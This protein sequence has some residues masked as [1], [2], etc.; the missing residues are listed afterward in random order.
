MRFSVYQ[1]SRRGGREKN[2]DRLGYCYTRDAGLFAL[3][4]GM[5]GHPDGEVASQLA[6]QTLAAHFQRISK[7]KLEDPVRF[8]REGIVKGHQQLLRYTQQKSLPDSPRTT[9]VACL[10]QDH[11]AYWA[12]CGDSRFYLIR[13]GRVLHRT[14]D[15]SYAELQE[16]LHPQAAQN[17][18][19][20]RNVLFTCLG[21]P[22][23]PVIDSVG[24]VELMHGDK[25][26]L[27]SDGLWGNMSDEEIVEQLS[28]Q[29]LPAAVPELVDRALRQGG[30]RCD[31]VSV[32]AIEWEDE[33]D[34][35]PTTGISTQS[36]A[37]QAFSSTIQASLASTPEPSMN[38]EEMDRSTQ[39]INDNIRR[40]KED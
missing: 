18:K 21:S 40:S 17:E 8:L 5:G 13:E 32:L 19:F 36:L 14:R 27:C 4:D 10:L 15:H 24:P 37:E 26:L 6:L 25:L 38:E 1:T 28:F 7:S 29:P 20:N 33:D 22:G 9:V 11:S 23:K 30:S 3:A 31:N 2:E 12:H 16:V 34:N 39:E 35:Q